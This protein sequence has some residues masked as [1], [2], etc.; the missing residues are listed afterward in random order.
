VDRTV[1]IDNALPHLWFANREDPE[2]PE[3]IRAHAAD[4]HSGLAGEPRM[5][6]RAVGTETWQE[7]AT[8]RS[9]SEITAR[10]NSSA[11]PAGAYEFLL[12]A[13]DVAGN[14]AASSKRQNGEPMV[15]R[16]PL[17]GTTVLDSH[18]GQGGGQAQTLSY[19]ESARA[20]GRLLDANGDP[21]VGK[22]II[23]VEEMH[24]G[25][26]YPRREGDDI[27]NENGRWS[28][29]IPPGPSG[30]VT[31]SYGGSAKHLS[32]ADR[33]GRITVKSAARFKPVRKRVPEGGTLRFRGSIRHRDAR[34]PRQGKQVEV[35]VRLDKGR[36]DTVKQAFHTEG[37]GSFG[38][39]Y[40]FGKHYV[41]D[42]RFRFRLEV[43]GE[44]DW[45][46]AGIVT[47]PRAVVVEAN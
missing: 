40:R 3:L 16:F 17:K 12:E 23:V 37:D 32:S 42:T 44:S 4:Q 33:I 41:Q 46:Y 43:S 11:V 29:E 38:F 19:G 47:K 36:W 5:Y 30:T 2:D 7:I 22:R 10:V 6:Y 35:Q 1:L 24:R 15:L 27:T 31:A 25:S 13:A 39:R 8:R 9:G 34:I 21:L 18:L 45:P 28:V 26:L 20:V 14:A